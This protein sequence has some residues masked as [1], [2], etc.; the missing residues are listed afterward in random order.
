MATKSRAHEG[1][2]SG[3]RGPALAVD[4]ICL[5]YTGGGI[6]GGRRKAGRFLALL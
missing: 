3:Q 5:P 4:G 1:G 6:L 2:G